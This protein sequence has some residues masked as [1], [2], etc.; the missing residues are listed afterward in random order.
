MIKSLYSSK[1]SSGNSSGYEKP[2][3][4][5]MLEG[6]IDIYLPDIKY[7]DS[8]PAK[9]YSGAEDYFEFASSAVLEMHRQ[10]GDIITDENG[11]AK[12]GIIIPIVTKI[13]FAFLFSW[14]G[15]IRIAYFS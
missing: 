2:E 13:A 14:F 4:L 1:R 9:K 11:I 3:T 6:L 12:K 7:F 15:K 10:V 5:K 8:A